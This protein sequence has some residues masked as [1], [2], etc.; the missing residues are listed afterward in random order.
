ME[1]D[2][3]LQMGLNIETIRVAIDMSKSVLADK[4]NITR[5]VLDNVL[6][7]NNCETDTL[8]KICRVF[9]MSFHEVASYHIY[10]KESVND[11][12]HYQLNVEQ[13]SSIVGQQ[14]ANA[15]HQ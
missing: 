12:I 9:N 4:A 1:D 10:N 11:R 14:N 5:A 8:K 13:Q 15:N 7:G 6:A 2:E 3:P